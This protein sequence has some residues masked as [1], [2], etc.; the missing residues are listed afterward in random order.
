MR[1]LIEIIEPLYEGSNL[2]PSEFKNRPKRWQTF[3]EKIK[4]K[5]PFTTTNGKKVVIEP[6]EADRFMGLYKNNQ[7]TG[8]LKARLIPGSAEDE[9]SL[10][11]LAKTT[12]FGGG[13]SE[14]GKKDMSA[15]KEGLLV[16]PSQI[17]I[18]DKQIPAEELYDTIVNNP[19]LKSTEYG[20]V[21][22]QLAEYIVAGEHVMLPEKYQS[23][24]HKKIQKAIEDYAGEYL[25]VL[26]LLYGRS[27]FPAKA[28]FL[29]WLGGSTDEL[30]LVWPGKANTA[31]ADSFATV[32]NPKTNHTLNISSKGGGG[33]AAPSISGLKIPPHV[34]LNHKLRT[35]VKFIEICKEEGTIEQAFSAM[36]LIYKTNPKKL[37]KEWFQYLPFATKSPQIKAL[38]EESWKDY[39][40]RVNTPLPKKY[41]PIVKQIGGQAS[42]GG[43]FIYAVKKAVAK[44]INED[45]AIP[46]FASVILEILNMNFIQQYTD[47]KSGEYTF[48]TQWPG[49]LD[50]EIS[51]TTKS[52]A[53]DPKSGGFSFKLGR[54]DDDNTDLDDEDGDTGIEDT[55]PLVGRGAEK[56]F[57]KGAAAAAD[58]SLAKAK[59][60]DSGR[61][62][63][64]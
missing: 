38:S 54:S 40:A 44:A 2:A 8:A 12:E 62:K 24:D 5:S 39:L 49:K 16:K 25:G 11:K 22:I 30:V 6:T 50:G 56:S 59:P 14:T 52:S 17:G 13:A 33:G 43:K 42:D 29:E 57:Q 1:D 36:D 9:I 21:V 53:S 3:I 18:V 23:K 61:K 28:R 37:P 55:E 64:R 20:R 7:F 48:A 63:R 58:P 10:S 51:V 31:L 60:R 4:S 46:E 15:G 32:T 35:A 41:Q 26:A 19:V 34:E 27:R 45:D 47:Y